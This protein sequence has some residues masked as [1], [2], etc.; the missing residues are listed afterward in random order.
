MSGKDMA[1][2]ILR[3]HKEARV[4]Y[5]SGHTDAAIVHHGVLHPGTWFVQKPFTTDI[6]TGK[7]R[8]LLDSPVGAV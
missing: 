4:L 6:L 3:N 8:D 2:E 1:V 7:V 5:M